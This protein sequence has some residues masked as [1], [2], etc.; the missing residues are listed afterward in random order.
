[1][2]AVTK[3]VM[4]LNNLFCCNFR[5]YLSLIFLFFLKKDKVGKIEEMQH[6]E[7]KL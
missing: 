4:Y 6:Q 1:V 5:R 2:T 3:T 7:L